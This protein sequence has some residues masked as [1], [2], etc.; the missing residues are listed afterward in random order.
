M[1]KSQTLCKNQYSFHYVFK[2]KKRHFTFINFSWKF[3]S[4]RSYTN[5]MTLCVTWSFYIHKSWY[6]SKSRTTYV[7]FLYTK[8]WTLCVTRFFIKFLKLVEGGAFL[9]AKNNALC[10]AFLYEKSMHFALRCF[11]T[12]I[13]TLCVTCLYAKKCTLCSFFISKTNR[14]VLVPNYKRTYDHI[15]K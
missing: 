14:V 2:Y 5:S 10:V 4:W 3:W 13:Q 11:Y 7:T 15:N 12:K 1:N 9:Y 6:L 8:I